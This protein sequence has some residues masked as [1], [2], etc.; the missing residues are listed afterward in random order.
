MAVASTGPRHD[1]C[2][3]EAHV[4]HTPSMHGPP[5]PKAGDSH[6]FADWPV[7]PAALEDRTIQGYLHVPG[8]SMHNTVG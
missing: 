8:G 1:G 5:R 7:K 2:W 3:A 4:R 6:A